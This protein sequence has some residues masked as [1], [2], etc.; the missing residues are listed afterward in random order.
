M[1]SESQSPVSRQKRMP[2]AE[3]S[4][5]SRGGTGPEMRKTHIIKEKSYILKKK[6][7]S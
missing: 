5:K 4:A 2:S 1:K 7:K 3:N 6:D